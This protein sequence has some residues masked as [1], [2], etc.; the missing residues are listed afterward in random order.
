M[1]H[2]HAVRSIVVVAIALSMLTAC[3]GGGG[4]E[5]N[6]NPLIIASTALPSA[7]SGQPV[8]HVIPVAGG[9]G[10]P[11]RLSVISGALPE[12]VALD[13]ATHSIVGTI[14]ESGNFSFR[15]QVIDTG[16]TP[17][18]ST[19]ADFAWT[20]SV[21]EV[22]IVG[23]TPS[24][25]APGT[26]VSPDG[27]VLNPVY[28][29]LP[30]TVYNQ[31]T[32]VQFVVAGGFPPYS[33]QII[34]D[35]ANP[36][37]GDLPQ[38][39][40]IPIDSC[41]IVGSPAEVRPGGA[42]F[43]LTLEAT[44]SRGAK[45]RLTVQWSITTPPIIIA[46]EDLPDGTQGQTFSAT[47][48]VVDG[49]PPFVY[50]FV[51]CDV[52]RDAEGEP[53]VTYQSPAPPT[54][55]SDCSRTRP[56]HANG[57]LTKIDA[58]Y[59]PPQNLLG[60]DYA[61]LGYVTP[62][63]GV[64]L[65]D[66][67]GNPLVAAGS[68]TG[69]PRRRGDFQ[70]N[71][72]VQS[73]LVPNERGQ[74]AWAHYDFTI[75]PSDTPLQ[76]DPFYTVEGVFTSAPP[77]SRIAE[78]EVGAP[79]NPD[80]S[81]HSPPGLL[82]R[83]D[84]GVP[85][86]GR[87]DA[88][89]ASQVVDISGS[90]PG[91]EFP[92]SFDYAMDWDP[93]GNGG[94]ANPGMAFDA[95]TGVFGVSD[96]SLLARQGPQ[97]VEFCAT[98]HALPVQ[99][100]ATACEK[101]T[102]SVG[103]D[104]VVVTQSSS[105]YTGT[106]YG[107]W[108]LNDTAMRLRMLEPFAVVPVVRDLT[109]DD[110]ALGS[111]IPATTGLGT[112]D[113][114][115]LLSALDDA[116][117]AV[118]SSR[119]MDLVR[120]LVNPTGW[121]DDSFAFNP[122]AA[123]PLRHADAQR[124]YVYYANGYYSH[125]SSMGASN[126]G[127]QPNASAVALPDCT[128]E[129]V[130]HD[131]ESGVYTDGGRLHA[132]VSG[133]FLGVFIVRPDGRIYV[134]CAFDKATTGF[135]AFGDAW[136]NATG[137]NQDSYL[138]MP[139]L[140]VSPDGRFAALKLK[141][142]DTSITDA[143]DDTRIVVFSLTGETAFDGETYKVIATGSDGTIARGVYQYAASMALSNTHLYYLCGNFSTSAYYEGAW[144]GHYIYRYEIADGTGAVTATAP[145]G[146]F[147]PSAVAD[148]SWTNGVSQP[149]QSPFHKFQVPNSGTS[150][151]SDLQPVDGGNY[152]EN[153]NAPV[154]FRV[155][156]DGTAVAIL[157]SPD[158]VAPRTSALSTSNV[159]TMNHHV[160]VD[161]SGAGV[162]RISS[163]KRHSPG[164][165]TRGYS[166]TYGPSTYPNWGRYTG[167]GGRFE[168]SDDASKVAVV[169]NRYSGSF[170]Y[171]TAPWWQA[172][173]DVV[174]FRTSDDWVTSTE[175]QVTGNDSGSGVFAGSS[176]WRF[177]ALVFTKDNQGLVFWGGCS[178]YYASSASTTYQMSSQM[179]GTLYG[180]DLSSA[181][182]GTTGVSVWGLLDDDDGGS[183][184]GIPTSAWTASSPYNP[185]TAT[186]SYSGVAGVI[187][188]VG[189]FLS[190][191]REFMYLCTYGGLASGEAENHRLIA[192]NVRSTNTAQ[193]VNGH[194]DFRAFAVGNWPTRRGFLP[195]YIYYPYYDIGPSQ[196]LYGQH[197][198][199]MSGA[200]AMTDDGKVFFAAHY[201]SGGPYNY[202]TS[203]YGGPINPIY[204]YDY[205]H[206]G[207]EVFAF[208][209]D[210]G[211]DIQQITSFTP[212]NTT[213]ARGITFVEPST[214][215]STVALVYNTGGFSP[216]KSLESLVVVRNLQW[217]PAGELETS[218]EGGGSIYDGP[219]RISATLAFGSQGDRVFFASG[220]TSNENAKEL[221]DGSLTPD[222][223]GSLPAPRM[224][225]TEAWYEILG[226]GR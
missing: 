65:G 165:A 130:S 194:T 7:L 15:I 21:G 212:A 101:V 47:L 118:D 22:R 159:D 99:L 34:D 223:S 62:P 17:F 35:P 96:E 224:L 38:G 1:G 176:L 51:S 14:L 95:A 9:H 16:G 93:D 134:P 226:A 81:I 90:G 29:A 83:V 153:N 215:G 75:L 148:A 80:A 59:Y 84:G 68:I 109:A 78:A 181:G 56:E 42:P 221:G 151:V 103:P 85:K 88:P 202:L 222:G 20:V 199:S 64:F 211:G 169:V 155:S 111:T 179:T 193:S 164:G 141:Q 147:L 49:V 106:S 73:N 41:S 214:D 192:V 187:K 167:P 135:R 161:V 121:W 129:H 6:T 4:S 185:S 188:P 146:A 44:D 204:S 97:E 79:Y 207:G 57:A 220:G 10:G 39:A 201:A 139:H 122:N 60:P 25:F 11:Y 156:R 205:N 45:G 175:I 116:G 125:S 216:T 74:H 145:S 63:E 131:P 183:T 190:R 110:L 124:S 104:R 86:D 154:P 150:L 180:V 137:T 27:S 128:S 28:P 105:S 76:H 72:H 87:T 127:W 77:Y 3:G 89:H 40:V 206:Y 31:F 24:M 160:W 46:T 184:A 142:S 98:D 53:L 171:S 213:T 178:S 191:N 54:V 67:D 19:T 2:V 26:Q 32:S 8:N 114:G 200:Q 115:Q 209:A 123:R 186:G 30:N 152:M 100:A 162:R 71:L 117:T 138:K 218:P 18:Q 195:T 61:G 177:G 48:I 52:A 174:A 113:V 94:T 119:T 157:A 182:P 43:V 210:V 172:R 66:E 55:T 69:V 132:F 163:V 82:V 203:P 12:G 102:F 36:D 208:D 70:V 158:H 108:G 13:D 5:P 33:C 225:G 107:G 149:M 133:D 92:G 189:G 170:S 144:H 37:D 126:A 140:T 198:Q 217:S 23:A 58:S 196:Y 166:L 112:T 219:G 120:V 143:A 136:V 91:Q 168:I 50:E 173:E 197:K